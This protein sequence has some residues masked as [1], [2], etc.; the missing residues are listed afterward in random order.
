MQCTA[1]KTPFQLLD[2]RT[3]KRALSPKDPMDAFGILIKMI[4]KSSSKGSHVLE[5]LINY[6]KF[7]QQTY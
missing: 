7:C 4:L 2:Q 3:L 5:F 1:L 6:F